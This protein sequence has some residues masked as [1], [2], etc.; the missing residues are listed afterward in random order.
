MKIA[1]CRKEFIAWTYRRVLKLSLRIA[2]MAGSDDIT[3]VHLAE[4]L[5]YLPKPD[6]Y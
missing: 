1:I 3:Q 6:S 4:A 5:Q 2:D